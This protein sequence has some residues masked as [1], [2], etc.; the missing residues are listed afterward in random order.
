MFMI[1]RPTKLKVRTRIIK[2]GSQTLPNLSWADV[3]SW[4]QDAQYPGAG[5]TSDGISVKAGVP[6]LITA[7]LNRNGTNGGNRARLLTTEN[8]VISTKNGASLITLDP[9]NYTPSVNT[10]I[11]MQGYADSG[12]SGNPT[13]PDD[14]NTF[15]FI[16]EV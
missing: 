14:S 1:I 7:A 16:Q 6:L 2:S 9:F 8:T 11:R 3:T 12:L 13:I 10:I 5:I 4:V 15:I